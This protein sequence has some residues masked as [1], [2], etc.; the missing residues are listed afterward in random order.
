MTFEIRWSENAR[1]S[2]RQVIDQ[3]RDK[4]TD[5][6]VSEFIQKTNRILEVISKSPLIYQSTQFP[7]VRRAVIS[8]QTSVL[9]KVSGNYIEVLF[10][11]DNRQDPIF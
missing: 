5:K 6:E 10:F 8:K 7:N 11:W 1:S 3:I 2:F 4:W 9:Y